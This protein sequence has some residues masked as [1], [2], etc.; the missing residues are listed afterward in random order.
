MIA[1]KW[2]VS[3]SKIL[4]RGEIATVLNKKSKKINGDI[5][6]L[7]FVPKGFEL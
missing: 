2:S 7:E 4:K 5:V 3:D 6:S 1:A